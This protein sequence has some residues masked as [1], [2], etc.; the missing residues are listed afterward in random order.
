MWNIKQTILKIIVIANIIIALIVFM[1]LM[2]FT[3]QEKKRI[4][5]MKTSNTGNSSIFDK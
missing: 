1:V 4:N 2:V 5:K 3:V